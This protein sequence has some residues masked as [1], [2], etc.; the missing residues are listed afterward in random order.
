M[1]R[2]VASREV[3][4]G[5]LLRLRVDEVE[6]DNGRRAQREIVEHPGA[7]AILA[8]TDNGQL[9]LVKQYRKAAE[10]Q[11]VEIPAGTL[12]KGEAPRDCAMREL[13]EETGFS[14]STLQLICTFY[15]AVGF[16]NEM[17]HL[18]VAQG[19]TAGESAQ[20]E[21]E[22]IELVV[23]PVADAMQMI[24]EGTIVDSKTVAGVFW[25]ELFQSGNPRAAQVC[26]GRA[27]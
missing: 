3:F 19:L 17:L 4:N 24:R 18:F 1:E 14:A 7:V 21:D 16:C 15:S 13:K 9:V 5:R 23:A 22:N 10:R 12:G 27:G 8:F 2:T 20:E 26:Q 6:L 11:T 25:A